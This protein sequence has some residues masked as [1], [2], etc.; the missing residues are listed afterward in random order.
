MF[1]ET[2]E[3][4]ATLGSF[5]VVGLFYGAF[6]DIIFFLRIVFGAG[7]IITFITDFLSVI[8]FLRVQV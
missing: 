4:L 5:F 8:L 3:F 2:G 6:Y 1:D 7:K